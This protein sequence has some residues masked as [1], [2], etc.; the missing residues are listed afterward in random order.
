MK[1]KIQIQQLTIDGAPEV[2]AEVDLSPRWGGKRR[3]AGRKPGPVTYR[4]I[5]IRL[6]LPHYE[7]VRGLAGMDGK[8]PSRW[9]ADFLVAS[10]DEAL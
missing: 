5:T 8:P 6:P 2:V 3:G 9:L 4:A 10:I 1:K 7:L